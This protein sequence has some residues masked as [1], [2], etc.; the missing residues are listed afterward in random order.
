MVTKKNPMLKNLPRY[1][2]TSTISTHSSLD[3]SILSNTSSLNDSAFKSASSKFTSMNST[4]SSIMTNDKSVY[5]SMN[6]SKLNGSLY[7]GYIPKQTIKPNVTVTV[8]SS[9]TPKKIEITSSDQEENLLSVF[10]VNIFVVSI[11]RAGSKAVF[12]NT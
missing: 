8:A 12:A 9:K 6:Q 10:T 2:S 4:M 3:S 5:I 1:G 7:K 11:F